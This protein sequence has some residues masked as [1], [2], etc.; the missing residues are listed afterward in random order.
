FQE[1]E[2]RKYG[3]FGRISCGFTTPSRSANLTSGLC[4]N[5]LR[6]FVDAREGTCTTWT[7]SRV[8]V[9]SWRA[10]AA[11]SVW[12]IAVPEVPARNF[13]SRRADDELLPSADEPTESVSANTTAIL[14]SG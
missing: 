4:R 12:A 8:I 10:L 7:P 2:F 3:S 6:A 5:A 14:A 1:G 11:A 13:T 9:L